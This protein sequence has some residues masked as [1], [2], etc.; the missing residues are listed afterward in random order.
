[1]GLSLLAAGPDRKTKFPCVPVGSYSCVHQLRSLLVLLFSLSAISRSRELAYDVYTFVND[2]PV[3]DSIDEWNVGER[4]LALL[5]E[6]P[7]IDY[8]MLPQGGDD[9]IYFIEESL[10]QPLT[11]L[12]KLVNHSDCDGFHSHGDAIDIL[13][14]FD[15]IQA[16]ANTHL[17]HDTLQCIRKIRTVFCQ[18]VQSR[19]FVYYC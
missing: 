10:I 15:F 2:D 3:G 5:R 13:S 6:P 12:V 19:L 17:D 8:G 14:M 18:A 9:H 4:C 16:E 1:M 11:G 7:D